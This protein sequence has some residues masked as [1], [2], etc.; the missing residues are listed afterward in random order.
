M[1]D[2]QFFFY[3]GGLSNEN[4]VAIVTRFN[5]VMKMNPTVITTTK[6]KTK[7]NMTYRLHFLR[8]GR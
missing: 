8:C 3:K 7:K 2:E 5:E 6:Y 4:T 1:K